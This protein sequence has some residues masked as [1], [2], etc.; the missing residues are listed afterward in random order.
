[1]REA[2]GGKVPLAR[3]SPW[4]DQLCVVLSHLHAQKPPIVHRDLKPS[5]VLLDENDRVMLIDFGIAKE[6][7]PNAV[8]R[9]IAR[10]A[11][12]GFSP[13]EQVMGTGTDERSDVYAL[14]ATL[15]VL[16]TGETP[17]PAHERVAGTEV[18]PPRRLVPDL[19]QAVENTILRALELNVARR[20]ATIAEFRRALNDVQAAPAPARKAAAPRTVVLAEATGTGPVAAASTGGTAKAAASGVVPAPARRRG[21]PVVL[22]ATIALLFALGA[23]AAWWLMR[24]GDKTADKPSVATIE[25]PAPTPSAEP[26]SIAPTAEPSQSAPPVAP[27]ATVTSL[28]SATTQPPANGP[29]ALDELLRNRPAEPEPE[30]SVTQPPSATTTS[31]P[32]SPPSVLRKPEAEPSAA[33]AK[34]NKKAQPRA[35]A[36]EPA[37]TGW[38]DFQGPRGGYERKI[39]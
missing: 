11:S 18:I 1:V 38:E 24:G 21:T 39:Q 37:G 17:P 9:T 3:L 32:S 12:H 36:R 7:A 2:E 26:V 23:G 27:T 15:Y 5:N 20:H 6:A 8:T 29:S 31:T 30:P 22:V 25:E 33:K 10:S 19:P 14:G 16:L 34:Q 35:S 4:I 28:P 13:P